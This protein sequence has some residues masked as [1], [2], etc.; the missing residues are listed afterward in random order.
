MNA[1]LPAATSARLPAS[2]EAARAAL[3]ECVNIDECQDWADRAAALASY[4]KQAEDR[5][6]ETM[7]QR[8]RAR[9]VRRAGELLKQVDRPEQGGRPPKNRVG[10]HPVS[11]A[12]AAAN[13]GLS[14]HQAKQAIRI[15]NV[16]EDDF[17]GQVESDTPPTLSAL[18]QQGIKPRPRRIVDLGE[19]DPSEFNR[20]MHFVGDLE[21]A[22]KLLESL[23]VDAI[24]P[25]LTPK[26]RDQSRRLVQRIDSIA[27][28]IIVRLSND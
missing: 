9:A 15:A 26:E 20:A 4:A 11:R 25:T 6:L 17:E 22:A 3:A 7:A 10:G 18:A 28:R 24:A 23:K 16:P 27:D 19:R 13:A 8:I 14:P 5:T 12:S 1:H 2:Y 21:D